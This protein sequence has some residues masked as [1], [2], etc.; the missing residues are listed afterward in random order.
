MTVTAQGSMSKEMSKAEAARAAAL[1]ARDAGLSRNAVAEV[2]NDVAADRAQ[3]H[4]D[5]AA[6]QVPFLKS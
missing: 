6:V 3:M 1:G 5:R 2:A 4:Q